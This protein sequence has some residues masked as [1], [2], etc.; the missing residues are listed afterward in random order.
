MAN[1]YQVRANDIIGRP[2][3]TEFWHHEAA[4]TICE[5]FDKLT[6]DLDVTDDDAAEV[7]LAIWNAACEECGE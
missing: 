3:K 2:L 1:K 6:N 4:K 5:T 7:I